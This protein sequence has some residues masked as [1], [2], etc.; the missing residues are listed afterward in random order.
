MGLAALPRQAQGLVDHFA[1][2]HRKEVNVAVAPVQPSFRQVEFLRLQDDAAAGDHFLHVAPVSGKLVVEVA[3]QRFLVERGQQVHFFKVRL[4]RPVGDSQAVVAVL[5][6]DIGVVLDIA[7]HVVAKPGQHLGQDLRP[8][9]DAT[10]L[11]PANH[12]REGL[13]RHLLFLPPK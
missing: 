8:Q 6:L 9:I 5:A 13:S 12:P 7:K 1:V 11:R 3:D 10:A 4:H 2:R